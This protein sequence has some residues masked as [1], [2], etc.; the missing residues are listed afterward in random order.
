MQEPQVGIE[1]TPVRLQGGC[2][3][4]LSFKGVS[5]RRGIRTPNLL[6]VREALSTVELPAVADAVLTVCQ[7]ED[8][9]A[10]HGV[11]AS[12]TPRPDSNGRTVGSK[13]TALCPLSYGA[14]AEAAGL[15]PANGLPS[16]RQ[17]RAALPT[18]PCLRVKKARVPAW[19]RR[20]R[21]ARHGR[22]GAQG[23]RRG[24]RTPKG[25]R[26]TRF[27]DGVP[28][29]WQSFRIGADTGSDV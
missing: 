24:S 5:P 15:E 6:F 7:G 8:S 10:N 3:A 12:R 18:R 13:P 1:P 14:E 28:R 9:R 4:E 20:G 23:G 2:S 16:T 19:S 21:A 22:S 17:Q 25:V 27:R 29:R 11:P 26:P